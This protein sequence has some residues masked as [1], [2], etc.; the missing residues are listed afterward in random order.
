MVRFGHVRKCV[1]DRPDFF[2]QRYGKGHRG[3]GLEAGQEADREDTVVKTS[4]EADREEAAVKVHPVDKAIDHD[5]ARR[6][7]RN[8][9]AGTG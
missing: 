9:D 4:L 7:T 5:Q 3:G 6:A 8:T 2:C 1:C